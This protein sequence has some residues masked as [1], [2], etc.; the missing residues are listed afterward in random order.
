MQLS[1]LHITNFGNWHWPQ[2]VALV[3]QCSVLF[4]SHVDDMILII[5]MDYWHNRLYGIEMIMILMREYLHI[6]RWCW[7]ESWLNIDFSAIQVKHHWLLWA[8]LRRSGERLN[9]GKFRF[10]IRKTFLNLGFNIIITII[11]NHFHPF[12]VQEEVANQVQIIIDAMNF[13]ENQIVRFAECMEVIELTSSDNMH[14]R[15]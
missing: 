13:N 12:Q 6:S 7:R 14:Q 11:S 3:A 1:W 5:M 8:H 15:F 9:L 10:W 4:I 2:Q